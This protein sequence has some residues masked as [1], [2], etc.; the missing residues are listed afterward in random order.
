MVYLFF[1]LSGDGD[2]LSALLT[3]GSGTGTSASLACDRQLALLEQTRHESIRRCEQRCRQRVLQRI[4]I[5]LEPHTKRV[6]DI[7]SVV[8]DEKT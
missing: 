6:L 2:E 4:A 5:L 3:L 8:I 1:V 7:A